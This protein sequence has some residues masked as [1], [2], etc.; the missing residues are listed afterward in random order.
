MGNN[1][2][3]VI[4][5]AQRTF[6]DNGIEYRNFSDSLV[7]Q[8]ITSP[9]ET[10]LF[11]SGG[12]NVTTNTDPKVSKLFKTNKFSNFVTL[13][14]L[15]L[16]ESQLN[17]LADNSKVKLNLDKSNLANYAYFGSLREF[18]R[19]SLEHIITSWPASI[20]VNPLVINNITNT[21][22]NY[23]YDNINNISTFRT[24]T[25]NLDNKYD[26]KFLNNGTTIDAYTTGTDNRNLTVNYSNYVISGLTGEFDIIGYT[27]ATSVNNDYIYFKVIG[28]PFT[29][30]TSNQIEYFHIKP[31]NIKV[32]E[33]FITLPNFEKYLLNRKTNPVYTATFSYTVKTDEGI[34]IEA[35][36]Q[37]TWPST[38][39]YNIDFNTTNY[40]NFVSNLLDLSDASDSIQ[41]NIISRFLVSN[42]ISDFDTVSKDNNDETEQKMD[43]TLKIYGREFDEIKHFADGLSLA[44]TV[45]YNKQD[46]APDATLKALARTLGWGLTSSLEG[47]DFI[48]SFLTPNTT[49]FSGETV[50][51]TPAEAEIE[52]WR[53]IILNTP[54][55]WKSKGTRKAIEFFFK[56]IGAPN[57]LIRFNEHVYKADKKL[58]IDTFLKV[59]EI[60]TSSTDISNIS[61]DSEGYPKVLDDTPNMYFQKAGLWYRQTGGAE[62]DVDILGGNNPHI[63]PYDGGNEYMNQ[64]KCLIPNFSSTTLVEETISTGTTNLFHNYNHGL[65]NGIVNTTSIAS[66]T[67]DIDFGSILLEKSESCYINSIHDSQFIIDDCN[68]AINWNILIYINNILE[69][70][71]PIFYSST[72]KTD[73]P[74]KESYINALQSGATDLNLT[75]NIDGDNATFIRQIDTQC[76]SVYT[77][78]DFN[79][80][81]NTDITISCPAWKQTTGVTD[82]YLWG[83]AY[84]NG[85]Y[86]TVGQVDSTNK[87]GIWYSIDRI[88]WT[89][90][91]GLSEELNFIVKDVI[92]A[93]NKFIAIGNATTGFNSYVSSD[94]ITW[95][96]YDITNVISDRYIL[97]YFNGLYYV[98]N[99]GDGSHNTSS[100]GI[101]WSSN[102]SNYKNT[103]PNSCVSN[104]KIVISSGSNIRSGVTTYNNVHTIYSTDGVNWNV[105]NP[106]IGM[107]FDQ[108]YNIVYN[109][110]MYIMNGYTNFYTSS[111]AINWTAT[112]KT[113]LSKTLND[114][115]YA[116]GEFVFIGDHNEIESTIDGI[117]IYQERCETIYSQS[118]SKICYGDKGFLATSE[119]SSNNILIS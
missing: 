12:F 5:Y 64:F 27:G 108:T 60:N 29:G 41:T 56:F 49:D 100:D 97:E 89:L 46:N 4:G 77:E 16:T 85:I 59:L 45:S 107:S 62:S 35:K 43:K 30:G 87:H 34:A 8:Q 55:I 72:G 86:V 47:N 113:I 10:T 24:S 63:G 92:Y 9:N 111:D 99:R 73:E 110:G 40:I 70:T 69:Y 3:K 103:T 28:N 54:W 95:N 76:N 57:G 36:K 66:C 79:I 17:V 78:S 22:E 58:D 105:S 42:A 93:N 96:K 119:S 18:V 117:T 90:I 14:T 104:D 65:I 94:G 50:G 82:S 19:I 112:P 53:R 81:L 7:G 114:S 13:N 37:I 88:V 25:N 84:G 33:F 1:R 91:T 116:N 83:C 23:V 71:G 44:N 38:D 80:N 67:T 51:L 21:V 39:G 61:I 98:I 75:L 102:T 48:T 2:I 32:N 26:I 15:V 52:M 74:T 68:Y 6:Y 20:F 118:F 106:C 109:D 115:V 31:N 11:T 101:T